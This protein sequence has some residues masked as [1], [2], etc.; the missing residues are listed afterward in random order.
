M[1]KS[2]PRAS[3]SKAPV[4]FVERLRP[5][6]KRSVLGVPP[7]WSVEDLRRHSDILQSSV[8]HTR[9][10]LKAISEEEIASQASSSWTFS[11]IVSSMATRFET[12]P[13][14]KSRTME[15]IY[16]YYRCNLFRI[17]NHDFT[18]VKDYVYRE[19]ERLAVAKTASMDYGTL[20][21]STLDSTISDLI[22]FQIFQRKILRN[23]RDLKLDA[24]D[25]ETQLLSVTRLIM[26]AYQRL[27]IKTR[28]KDA[29]TGGTARSSPAV[30][31]TAGQPSGQAPGTSASAGAQSSP[32]H[33]TPAERQELFDLRETVQRLSQGSDRAHQSVTG[34][35]GS[36]RRPESQEVVLR[37]GPRQ[38]RGPPTS[39]LE[40]SEL[41]SESVDSPPG[42]SHGRGPR[43]DQDP[44]K[45]K[46]SDPKR[47]V[48]CLHC[49]DKTHPIFLCPKFEKLDIKDKYKIVWGK[50]I[51]IRCLKTG[52]IAKDCKVRFLCNVD[53]CGKRH[54]KF[55]H[56]N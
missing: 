54:H 53:R 52:H 2:P 27:L 36:S 23:L 7:Y 14:P 11:E 16:Y 34:R 25:F 12:D 47:Y 1:T 33:L 15:N 41:S 17:V 20:D 38:G 56:T 50:R 22:K 49:G 31:S 37:L 3:T 29:T 42:R 5:S 19:V 18:E 48:D 26:S 44:N 39:L 4:S 55:L 28:P 21:L 46:Q 8:R 6:K 10:S 32:G 24:Y 30:I 9:S 35:Q 13:P 40:S 45:P 51:C 43:K